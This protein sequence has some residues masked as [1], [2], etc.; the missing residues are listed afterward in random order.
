MSRRQIANLESHIVVEEGDV[1]GLMNELDKVQLANGKSQIANR[2]DKIDFFSSIQKLARG[3]L[4]TQLSVLEKLLNS[5]D[6]GK[7]FNILAYSVDAERQVKMA[8]Y[9]VAVKS[10]KLEYEEVLLTYLL[11]SSIL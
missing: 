8:D 1:Y 6:A 7:V 10:G 3:N 9:D 5:E 4:Q 2:E 11:D